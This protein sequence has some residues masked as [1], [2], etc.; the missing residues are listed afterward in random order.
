MKTSMKKSALFLISLFVFAA[1]P[2]CWAG[3]GAIACSASGACTWVQG[4]PD[5]QMAVDGA[6]NRCQEE[7]GACS[8]RKWEHNSCVSEVAANGNVAQ[9]CY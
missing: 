8:L 3:W 2:A 4:A 5:Y 7:Y 6:L 1:A 9:A